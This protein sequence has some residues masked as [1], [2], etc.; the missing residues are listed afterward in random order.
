[1]NNCHNRNYIKTTSININDIWATFASINVSHNDE[2]IELFAKVVRH[3]VTEYVLC[4]PRLFACTS[5]KPVLSNA[6]TSLNA[7]SVDIRL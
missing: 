1:M 5:L 4:Y 7:I 6:C 2:M 3:Y